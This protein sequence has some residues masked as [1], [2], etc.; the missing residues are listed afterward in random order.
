M[1]GLRGIFGFLSDLSCCPLKC[2][3]GHLQPLFRNQCRNFDPIGTVPVAF[4]QVRRPDQAGNPIDGLDSGMDSMPFS[5]SL[6][7]DTN[8]SATSL[9]PIAKI[10]GTVLSGNAQTL[11]PIFWFRC[12]PRPVSRQQEA[13][14]ASDAFGR[15]YLIYKDLV[16]IPG[17]CIPEKSRNV[18]LPEV[19]CRCR[20]TPSTCAAGRKRTPRGSGSG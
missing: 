2:L 11:Q 13:L 1:Y 15:K 5:P 14:S 10:T 4:P 19:G 9:S 3:E 12:R 20:I 18:R 16:K 7:T 6:R 8:P 17:H